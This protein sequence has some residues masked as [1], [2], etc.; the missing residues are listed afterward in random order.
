[1]HRVKVRVVED[2][3]DANATIA[4]ANRSDFDRAGVTVV[5]LM[6]APG[7]GKTTLLERVL[8]GGVGDLRVGVLEG[9]VQGSL[10][11]DRLAHLHVPVTQL[12]TGSGYGGAI[13]DGE[14]I[15]PHAMDPGSMLRL[16]NAIGGFSGKVVVIGC[17]PGEVDDVGLG[18]TPPVEAA[19][20]GAI[21]LVL[22]TIATLRTDAAYEPQR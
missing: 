11:A 21:D 9:D 1:M 8:G 6:S 3:L 10:D 22:E 13:E 19:V 5:N 4:R 14:T 16:V 15:N 17:E 20:A 18:L 7:A 12:N 2:A